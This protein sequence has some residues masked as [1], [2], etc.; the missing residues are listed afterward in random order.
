MALRMYIFNDL[1]EKARM[2]SFF[3]GKADSVNEYTSTDSFFKV[4]Q[5]TDRFNPIIL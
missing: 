4:N 5:L 2:L 1:E 3:L